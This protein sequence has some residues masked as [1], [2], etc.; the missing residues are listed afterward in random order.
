MGKLFLL[1]NPLFPGFVR[2]SYSFPQTVFLPFRELSPLMSTPDPE[3]RPI[4][5]CTPSNLTTLQSD[6]HRQ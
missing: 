6:G 5:L 3:L 2:T 1:R 4:T